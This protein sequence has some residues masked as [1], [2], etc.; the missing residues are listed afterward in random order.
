MPEE[1]YHSLFSDDEPPAAATPAVRQRTVIEKESIPQ[2]PHDLSAQA[3]ILG[4]VLGAAIGDAMGHP[5]EFIRSFA[6]I[7]ER[8]GP[9]GVRKFELF[10]EREGR[11]F[12]PYTD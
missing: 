4:A 3:R 12:A 10:W 7:H 9:E 1:F 6:G 5:T 8:Y 11:R 2:K